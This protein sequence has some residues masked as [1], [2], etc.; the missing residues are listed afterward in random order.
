MDQIFAGLISDD[1]GIERQGW[2][3]SPTDKTQM[4][5]FWAALTASKIDQK[6]A[7][8]IL[9]GLKMIQ[10][11]TR[12]AITINNK[13]ASDNWSIILEGNDRNGYSIQLIDEK[14]ENT[15]HL[16]MDVDGFFFGGLLLTQKSPDGISCELIQFEQRRND[17]F[18]VKLKEDS[19]GEFPL[20]W[21]QSDAPPWKNAS[22]NWKKQISDLLGLVS[23]LTPFPSRI[24]ETT[25]N[26]QPVNQKT[27]DD[28]ILS[29]T[30]PNGRL[31]VWPQGQTIEFKEVLTIGRDKDNNLRLND[32]KISRYHVVIEYVNSVW[33]IRNIKPAPGYVINS[34][35]KKVPSIL[36]IGDEIILGDTRLTIEDL[37][38]PVE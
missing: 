3:S 26:Q 2:I 11:I 14:S 6:Q 9:T 17:W 15:I 16:Q 38:N 32:P 22:N 13:T 10:K 36:N 33:Q 27:K 29:L 8:A 25:S 19:Q 31:V 1:Q 18:L 7:E 23:S 35:L 5:D 12:D 20:H 37:S 30:C 28:V 4:E 34:Q 24:P 21:I